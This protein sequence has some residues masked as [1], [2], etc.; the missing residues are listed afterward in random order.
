[1]VKHRKG[2]ELEIKIKK[3]KKELGTKRKNNIF[4]QY[5]MLYKRTKEKQWEKRNEMKNN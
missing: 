2:K 3:N 5:S 4:I 1:M